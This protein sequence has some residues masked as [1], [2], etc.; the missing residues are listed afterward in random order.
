MINA[1]PVTNNVT[2]HNL[3][4]TVDFAS[5]LVF[6]NAYPGGTWD[7][8][9]HE[10]CT[11]ARVTSCDKCGNYVLAPGR[12]RVPF[13]GKVMVRHPVGSDGT[14][15]VKICPSPSSMAADNIKELGFAL[16]ID[17]KSGELEM[18]VHGEDGYFQL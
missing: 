10:F 7:I 15:R 1:T 12:S 5:A 6:C 2:H 16:A 18:F 4:K 17:K 11:K 14:G 3:N 8:C 9:S 13:S